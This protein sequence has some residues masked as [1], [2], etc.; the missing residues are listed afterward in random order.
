[1]C[2]AMNVVVIVTVISPLALS[3]AYPEMFLSSAYPEI[4]TYTG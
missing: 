2:G 1:M 3:S 4:Q